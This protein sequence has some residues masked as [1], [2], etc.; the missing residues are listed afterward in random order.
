MSLTYSPS[1]IRGKAY[2]P[3]FEELLFQNKTISEGLVGFETDVKSETI[4]SENENTV[5]MQAFASGAPSSSGDLKVTDTIVTPTK[6][7][8]YNEFNPDTLRTSRFKRDMKAG[9]WNVASSE[10]ER[11]VLAAYGNKVSSDSEV[12]FWTGITSATKSAIAA[13]T[14]GTGQ[15][16]VGAKEQTWAAAQTAGQIDGV[17]AK[18]IYNNGALG[19]RIKRLGATIDA[20]N[21]AAEYAKAYGDIPAVVLNGVEKPL[22]YAPYSHKQFINIYNVTATYRDLF[23]V[24]LK[25]DKYFYNGVEIKFVP[26][27]ENAM[28]VARPSHLVWCTDLLADINAMVIDKIANNREDMFVKHIFTIAAHVGN[29]KYNVLYLG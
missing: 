19:T 11:V 18:M 2:E 22:I 7:M 1:A 21:I 8:Y 26:L 24:D 15:A 14:P 17:V 13:L 4:F 9:A 16:A 10:F 12:A 5:A 28:I 29:Q 23:S 3:I 25:A 6:V 27:S 20:T